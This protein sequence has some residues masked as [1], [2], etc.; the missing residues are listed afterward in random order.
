MEPLDPLRKL[1]DKDE[2][3]A[4]AVAANTEVSRRKFGA[5][6]VYVPPAVLA[7]IDATKRPALAQS[8]CPDSGCPQ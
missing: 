2:V 8:G 4:D 5:K 6:L 1:E 7:V 3:V